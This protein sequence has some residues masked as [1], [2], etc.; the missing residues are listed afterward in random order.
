MGKGVTIEK[1]KAG[2]ITLKLLLVILLGLFLVF[3]FGCSIK[4]SLN[5]GLTI[6]GVVTNY[7]DNTPAKSI[8]VKLYTYHPDPVLEYLPPTGHILNTAVTN[9]EGKYQLSIDTDLFQKL[10]NQDY[11]KVVVFVAQG[12]SGFKVIDLADETISVDLVI[13]APA[14]STTK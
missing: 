6:T 5:T 9:E 8:E 3:I 12:I 13:G 11:N 1:Y 7:L 14:P 2:T 4:S 10:E